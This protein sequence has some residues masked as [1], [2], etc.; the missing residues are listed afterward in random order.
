MGV[1]RIAW[2]ALLAAAGLSGALLFEGA[3]QAAA[4]VLARGG[5]VAWSVGDALD[6]RR[7]DRDGEPAGAPQ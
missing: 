3:A 5:F 2:V 6:R 4:H 7:A 1:L